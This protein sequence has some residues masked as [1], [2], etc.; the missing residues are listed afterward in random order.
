[1]CMFFHYREDAVEEVAFLFIIRPRRQCAFGNATSPQKCSKR[2]L[3]PK[4]LMGGLRDKLKKM[5]RKFRHKYSL[6]SSTPYKRAL[7]ILITLLSIAVPNQPV[8]RHCF[9]V[10]WIADNSQSIRRTRTDN[11]VAIPADSQFFILRGHNCTN[12]Q[13]LPCAIPY[14]TRH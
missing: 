13:L 7:P 4:R 9:D 3:S 10:E 1:M 14:D 6:F 2:P 12:G 8:T 5:G 11:D